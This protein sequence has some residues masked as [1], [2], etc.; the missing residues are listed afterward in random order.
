MRF[1]LRG[2]LSGNRNV[3]VVS[4]HFSILDVVFPDGLPAESSKSL[5][6]SL[7]KIRGRGLN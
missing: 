4:F 2:I 3:P 7:S 5:N 1:C 6:I